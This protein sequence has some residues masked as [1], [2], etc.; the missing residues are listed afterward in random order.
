MQRL[1][2]R[3]PHV[4]RFLPALLERVVFEAVTPDHPVIAALDHLRS[5]EK[6]VEKIDDAPQ[7]V[8][9]EAWRPLVV[10]GDGV[11]DRRGYTLCVLDRLRIALRRRDVYVVGADRWGDPRQLLVEP[12]TWKTVGPQV[13]RTLDLPER[14]PS[15]LARLGA[16][17][18]AAYFTAAE[19]VAEDPTLWIEE[20]GSRDRVHV[21]RLDRLEE[22]ASTSV[23]RADTHALLPQV[24]L[25]E[26][27]LEVHAW[28]G[29]LDEFTHASG[30]A[31]RPSDLALSV[32]AVVVAQACNIGYRPVS[33]PDVPAL[34]PARLEWV[35]ANFFRPETLIAANNRLIA[36]H[37]TIDLTR[38]WGSGEIASADGLRF[39]VPVRSV[40]AG[41]NPHYFGTGRGVTYY[42]WSSDQFTSWAAI[43]IPGT[44]RD[45]QFILD[46]LLD[47]TSLL[48][49]REVMA[50]TAADSYLI[51][52]LFR[53]L[54]YQFSPRLADL[55][56]RRYW[57]LN[58]GADYGAFNRVATN[59]VRRQL[60]ED[61]WP[62]ICRVAGTLQTRA[63]TASDLIRVLQRSGQPTT[64]GRAVAELGR[65]VQTIT[66]LGYVSD[67][68]NRRRVLV[69]L[70]RT[71]ARHD[72]AR[73]VFHGRRGDLYQAYRAGQ[74]D[75]LGALGLVLNAIALFN[76]RYL[77]RA[78]R[79]VQNRG[80]A[81]DDHDLERL[82]PLVREHIE[83]HGRYS[84]SL[85]DAVR[86]GDLRPLPHQG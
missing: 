67:K 43:V 2:A 7:G 21:A 5:V 65:I 68:A 3:Y 35:V 49:P 79:Y 13:L 61:N 4:R 46:G 57:R 25:P 48:Q 84:F 11:P 63:A 24:E 14:A 59:R 41:A 60:I 82:S 32:C 17:L 29:F 15:Y 45:S 33:R 47:N 80:K 26:L 50:D 37:Q 81:V 56:D 62:D 6:G 31:A 44:L 75:Q 8:I 73:A 10:A 71:E 78:V 51:H 64:L 39:V 52:G 66:M 36:H 54:G 9:T 27:L 42:N 86:A 58:A 1:I 70:N 69:Q 72:L 74:E 28:T 85:P 19:A 18:D 22:P 20:A 76:T 77:D 55:P 23:L 30:S 38:R 40:H 16:E 34:T 83:L 12:A 53:L